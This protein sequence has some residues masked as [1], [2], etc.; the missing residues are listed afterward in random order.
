[1]AKKGN[2]L[3]NGDFEHGTTEGWKV[4]EFGLAGDFDLFSG[5][6]G[7]YR[8][9]YGGKLVAKKDSAEGYVS[10]DRFCSFEEY[11]AYLMIGYVKMITTDKSHLVLYGLD[12][13]GNYI[14]K[15]AIGYNTDCGV[16]KRFSAILRGFGEITN[17]KVGFYIFSNYE[18]GYAYF[19]EFKL[20]PLKSITAHRIVEEW[21]I[22]GLTT[23][24]LRVF[25][26]G[27]V[28]EC[29]LESLLTV[30]A[31]SGSS[32][33]LDVRIEVYYPPSYDH[34][35]KIYHSQFT[36]TGFERVSADLVDGTY[37]WIIYEVGGSSPSFDITHQIRLI[38]KQ[39]GDLSQ[40]G[41]AL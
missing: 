23:T 19:D 40:G 36:N 32:P 22:D 30:R 35:E 11:E 41:G 5:T 29:R 26:A 17:F 18:G 34:V 4:G 12:D 14:N 33:T 37:M 10:Y 38:P 15:F 6:E 16:W 27:I 39:C 9:S 1:M 2:L 24:K 20:L 8:G 31:V 25:P 3:F 28:G 13:N 7:A 21:K